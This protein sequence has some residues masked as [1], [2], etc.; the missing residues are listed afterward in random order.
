MAQ[1]PLSNGRKM[2]IFLPLLHGI[3]PVRKP[4]GIKFVDF[5]DQVRLCIEFEVG[6]RLSKASVKYQA[7]PCLRKNEYGLVNIGIGRSAPHLANFKYTTVKSRLVIKLGERAP[8][9]I[10]TEAR[11]KRFGIIDDMNPFK[12]CDHVTPQKVES[13]VNSSVGEFLQ[14]RA[15]KE[16]DTREILTENNYKKP[17]LH[18]YQVFKEA[19][20]PK[21]VNIYSIDGLDCSKLPVISVDLTTCGSFCREKFAFDL[22]K[23]LNTYGHLLHGYIYKFDTISIDEA[24]QPHDIEWNRI[25]HIME[26]TRLRYSEMCQELESAGR[27][28]HLRFRCPW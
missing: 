8:W 18:G 5:L 7:F 14:H 2:K 21:P 26:K 12:S 15:P 19:A 28:I 9:S 17:K 3:F 1:V 27:P 11:Q 10:L 13:I 20:A 16:S 6:F 23:Q 22:G 24:L 4:I 25:S